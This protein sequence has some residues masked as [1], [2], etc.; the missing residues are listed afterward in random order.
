[1]K[2]AEVFQSYSNLSLYETPYMLIPLLQI[3]SN[4]NKVVRFRIKQ[5][6]V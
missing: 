5:M 2:I 1:M 4:R 6:N 3:M